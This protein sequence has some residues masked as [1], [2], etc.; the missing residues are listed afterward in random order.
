MYKVFVDWFTL[1]PEPV[2]SKTLR[3]EHSYA[4]RQLTVAA[5]IENFLTFS[6]AAP[7]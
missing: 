5:S 2:I 6:P 3:G 1:G 7:V 4:V